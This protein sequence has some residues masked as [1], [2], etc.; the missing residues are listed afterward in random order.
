MDSDPPTAAQ[1]ADAE[2]DIHAAIDR[3]FEVVPAGRTGTIVGVA[4]SITTVT[5]HALGLAR[6]DPEAIHGA[7]LTID[8]ATASC[9]A[10]IAATRAQRAAMPYMHPGRVDSIGAGALVWRTVLRRVREEVR[11]AGGQ[12]DHAVT[13]EHDIL[14]GVA[15]SL[16]DRAS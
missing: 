1:I 11:S 4:G 13:S 5:A 12:L 2:Q 8:Q 10:L 14:D 6:Y 3:A 7:R 16:A 15:L 9:D